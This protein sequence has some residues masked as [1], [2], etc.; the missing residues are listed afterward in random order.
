MV[1][2]LGA[3]LLALMLVACLASDEGEESSDIPPHFA[4]A[5]ALKTWLTEKE[6]KVGQWPDGELEALYAELENGESEL[7]TLRV[8]RPYSGAMSHKIL[9]RVRHV[10]SIKVRR[11]SG[12]DYLVK[13]AQ[14]QPDSLALTQAASRR[15]LLISSRSRRAAPLL[16]VSDTLPIFLAV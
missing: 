4:D 3:Q 1:N 14:T 8:H 9:S 11:P 15:N 16:V 10:L 7:R 2:G 13:T 6:V 12:S 5:D